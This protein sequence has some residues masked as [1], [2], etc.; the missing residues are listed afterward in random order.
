MPQVEGIRVNRAYFNERMDRQGEEC[1]VFGLYL[2]GVSREELEYLAFSGGHA[3][4]HRGEESGGIAIADGNTLHQPFKEMGLLST[5]Y[6]RYKQQSNRPEG[7]IA[8]VHNRY[9]T[10]GSSRIENAAPFITHSLLGK[11]ALAHNGNLTNSMELRKN[12][13]DQGVNFKGTTD[14]EVM[15]HLIARGTGGTWEERIKDALLQCQGS[16]SLVI[17]TQNKLFAA[18]DRFGIRPLYMAEIDYQGK[19]GYA[20][21]SETTAFFNLQCQAID[22]VKRGAIISFGAKGM[23][24]LKF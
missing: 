18:R 9:S 5:V 11:I 4:Q 3:L 13:E 17:V 8:I 15:V 21:S 24:S 12:L 23:N 16:F 7:H 10:I 19:K 2:P 22:E 6:S 20:V 1:G 14:S